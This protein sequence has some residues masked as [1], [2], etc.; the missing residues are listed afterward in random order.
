M[1][2]TQL[3][4][5]KVKDPD[6]LIN[7]LKQHAK[8]FNRKNFAIFRSLLTPSI[9]ILMTRY[10]SL[11]ESISQKVENA[12]S[13]MQEKVGG[14]EMMDNGFYSLMNS[15]DPENSLKNKFAVV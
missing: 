1:T 7:G 13:N 14:F 15:N 12:S 3:R 6:K 2:I 10:E 5:T 8:E 4:L 11:S 9:F